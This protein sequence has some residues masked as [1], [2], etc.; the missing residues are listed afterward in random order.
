VE[1]E[2][3]STAET[4]E[5]QLEN[6]PTSGTNRWRSWLIATLLL[7][8]GLVH[9]LK[10]QWLTLD[11]PSIVL[12]MVGILLIF[13]PLDDLGGIIESLEIGNTK[14][15]FRKVKR[16]NESVSRAEATTGGTTAAVPWLNL[17]TGGVGRA[18]G[19]GG[20]GPIGGSS[21]SVRDDN[22][23]RLL[24]GD[25]ELV[26]I[27]I[28]V[29]LERRLSELAGDGGGS[30]SGTLPWSRLIAEL[31][32]GNVITKETARALRNFGYVRNLLVHH[33]S[34]VPEAAVTSAIDSGIKLLR[35]LEASRVAPTAGGSAPWTAP[36]VG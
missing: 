29:E 22:I 12:I 10:P 19:T 21:G 23:E 5:D 14:I 2:R 34:R 27:K 11:W 9:A 18:S 4:D 28:G 8:A 20:S 30:G 35:V 7:I 3:V 25:K 13:V 15:L 1:S 32:Q 33:G 26:L 24:S 16:L 31:E 17:E 6:G 36:D